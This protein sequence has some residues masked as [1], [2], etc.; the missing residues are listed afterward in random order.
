[1]H[2]LDSFRLGTIRT[3]DSCTQYTSIMGQNSKYTDEAR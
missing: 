3:V 2:N 1:M